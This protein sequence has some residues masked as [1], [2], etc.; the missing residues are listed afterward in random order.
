VVKVNMS[1][2]VW[3]FVGRHFNSFNCGGFFFFIAAI[4]HRPTTTAAFL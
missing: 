2:A 3:L 1:F 4:F